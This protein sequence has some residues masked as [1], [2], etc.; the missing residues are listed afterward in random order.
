MEDRFLQITNAVYKLL[1]FFPEGEP[2]KNR[3]KDKALTIMENLVLVFDNRGWASLRRE[4]ASG[5]LLED[6]EVL[7]SYFKLGK[8]LGWID[9]VNFLIISKEY[10]KIK[11]EIRQ[12]IEKPSTKLTTVAIDGARSDFLSKKSDLAPSPISER[13]KKILKFLEEKE[14][15]QV[16]DFT[17]ILPNITKRTIRRDLDDLLKKEKIIRFGEW[18]QVF[19]KILKNTDEKSQDIDNSDRTRAMSQ[20]S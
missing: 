4:K 8:S 11:N 1:E 9:S 6:I 17:T 18:N 7:L 3:A 13:Q 2:L 12:L 16:M 14:K 10:D 20:Q 5:Q 19:Y 15:G